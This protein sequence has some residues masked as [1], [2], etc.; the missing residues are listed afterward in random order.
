MKFIEERRLTWTSRK[1]EL[2]LLTDVVFIAQVFIIYHNLKLLNNFN[3]EYQSLV[4]Q[5]DKW[6][7]HQVRSS[8][9]GLRHRP[10]AGAERDGEGLRAVSLRARLALSQSGGLLEE[11]IQ[12]GQL[13]CSGQSHWARGSGFRIRASG[14]RFVSLSF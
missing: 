10:V 14:A 3:N 5:G 2:I 13:L 4:K 11:D 8:R 6:E 9:G 1:N 7:A 12:L